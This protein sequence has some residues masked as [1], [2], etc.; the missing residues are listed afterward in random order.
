VPFRPKKAAALSEAEGD[1]WHREVEKSIKKQSSPLAL[2]GLSTGDSLKRSTRF[3]GH[4]LG[5]GLL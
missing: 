2:A 3:R 1:T 4:K 5:D